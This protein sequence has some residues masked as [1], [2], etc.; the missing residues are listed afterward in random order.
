MDNQFDIQKYLETLPDNVRDFIDGEEWQ[1]RTKQVAEKYGLD[2]NQSDSLANNVCLFIVGLTPPESLQADIEE[3]LSISPIVSEQILDDLDGRV[4]DFALKAIT[5]EKKIETISRS[6]IPK[7]IMPQSK[8][9]AE[10]TVSTSLTRSAEPDRPIN[11]PVAEEDKQYLTGGKIDIPRYI[12][13]SVEGAKEEDAKKYEASKIDVVKSMYAPQTDMSMN[14]PI[15]D[16]G[17]TSAI[18]SKITYKSAETAPAK[19]PEVTQS[20]FQIPRINL[21]TDTATVVTPTNVPEP[22]PAPYNLDVPQRAA[23]QNAYSPKEP[24]QNEAVSP[25][26]APTPKPSIPIVKSYTVDPYREPLQ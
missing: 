5:G 4:F 26:P 16:A 23:V 24:A 6:P 14:A 7:V 1:S 15:Q 10:N 11:L 19:Q 2:E 21:N 12:P 3:D 22:A 17:F 25:E 9:E 18:G 13:T 8:N 20:I